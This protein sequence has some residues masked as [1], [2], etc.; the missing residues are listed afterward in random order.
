MEQ[1]VVFM[2]RCQHFGRLFHHHY[3]LGSAGSRLK[4]ERTAPG[5][6]IK[7]MPAVEFLAQPVEQRFP[8]PVRRRPQTDAVR[9]TQ[10]AAPEGTAND[11][12]AVQSA[13]TVTVT[14]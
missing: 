10:D 2:Q 5:E 12:D 6:E 8:N 13:A 9:K 1:F 7:A 4:T 11:T 3:P 14:S